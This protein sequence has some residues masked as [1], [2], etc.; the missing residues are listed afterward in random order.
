MTC[1]VK[2]AEI[3]NAWLFHVA[4]RDPSGRLGGEL[5][6]GGVDSTHYTG[7]VHYVPV[8]SDT[9]WLIEGSG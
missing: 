3:N 9:Y 2:W 1:L 7:I 6:L 4:C 5:D 8:K